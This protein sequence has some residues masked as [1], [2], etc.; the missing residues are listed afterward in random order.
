VVTGVADAYL[1]VR[2]VLDQD[3]A[4][5]PD[6]LVLDQPDQRVEIPL[7]RPDGRI[8]RHDHVEGVAHCLLLTPSGNSPAR[9][10]PGT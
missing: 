6:R 7:G 4:L 3:H 9:K 8:G 5:R 2:V 10:L 1:P